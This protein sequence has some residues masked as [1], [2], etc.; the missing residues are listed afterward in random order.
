MGH[1]SE[2]IVL[3]YPFYI[4]RCYLPVPKKPSCP[5]DSAAR[6]WD[7]CLR[8]CILDIGPAGR[9]RS[10]WPREPRDY[11][12]GMNDDSWIVKIWCSAILYV[13]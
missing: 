12:K 10:G 11:P 2:E 13:M 4:G 5:A 7:P 3:K 6:G 9:A 8:F 1:G